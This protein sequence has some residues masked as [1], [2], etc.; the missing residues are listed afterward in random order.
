MQKGGRKLSVGSVPGLTMSWLGEILRRGLRMTSLGD[1]CPMT[2]VGHDGVRRIAG[3][4][5]RERQVR[6]DAR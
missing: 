2:N 1:G 6:M 4:E 3:D 5:C